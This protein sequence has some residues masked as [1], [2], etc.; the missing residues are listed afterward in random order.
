MCIHFSIFALLSRKMEKEASLFHSDPTTQVLADAWNLPAV[1]CSHQKHA[2]VRRSLG[3]MSQTIRTKKDVYF[4]KIFPAF[5]FED[6]ANGSYKAKVAKVT[7]SYVQTVDGWDIFSKRDTME[8]E[9]V[10]ATILSKEKLEKF[11]RDKPMDYESETTIILYAGGGGFLANLQ[12]IQENYLKKWA[13]NLNLTI[14]EAHYPLCPGKK[15]PYQTKELFNLY[16]QIVLHYKLVRGVQRLKVALVGDSAGGNIILSLMNVLA[17]LDLE[18]TAAVC[19]I[20]PPVDLRTERFT[21]SMLFSMEDQLLYFT[22]AKACFRAYVPADVDVAGDWL[23]STIMAPDSIL[24]R[25]PLSYFF[26]GEKDTHRYLRDD[27]VR[28]AFRLNELNPSKCQLIQVA[29]VYHGF[30][31]FQIPVGLGVDEVS[32]IHQL[33]QSYLASLLA[34]SPATH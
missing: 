2:I 21:P 23:L 34:G 16:M 1:A 31:G 26:C 20:Y 10:K 11:S 17:A 13:K 15:D 18:I 3:I 30:L 4:R 8:D 27:C 25:Y 24:K 5:T 14:F 32:A 28:M 33:V 7:D 22:I 19:V 12:L 6:I 29:G 9:I